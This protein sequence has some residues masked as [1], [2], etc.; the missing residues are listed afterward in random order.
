MARA[1]LS[2]LSE[3]GFAGQA[4]DTF[5]CSRPCERPKDDAKSDGTD[6]EP[7]P[8]D[9]ARFQQCR[10]RTD[11]N[12]VQSGERYSGTAAVVPRR[13]GH[14][15]HTGPFSRP[16]RDCPAPATPTTST[17]SPR[18]L[19]LPVCHQTYR[20]AVLTEP[21]EFAVEERDEPTPAADEVL[22][23]IREVGICGSDVHYYEH[24]HIGDKVV[25][26]PL[27]LGHEVRAKS[28]PWA[29]PSTP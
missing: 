2:G 25:E 1:R 22:I 8:G 14:Q 13:F 17:E 4:V 29:M 26:E 7:P 5:R 6:G 9:R 18:H 24:G 11:E 20:V 21:G 16:S 19:P 12:E 3:T 10:R 28:K 15:S 27:V 23:R